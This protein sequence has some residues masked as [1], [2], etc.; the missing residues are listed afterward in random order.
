MQHKKMSKK[1]EVPITETVISKKS[2]DQPL[3]YLEKERLKIS[4]NDA[5]VRLDKAINLLSKLENFLLK[6]STVDNNTFNIEKF[7]FDKQ[8]DEDIFYTL[9]MLGIHFY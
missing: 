1:I 4:Y 8:T 2:P 6:E 7:I 3:T 5:L 9:K